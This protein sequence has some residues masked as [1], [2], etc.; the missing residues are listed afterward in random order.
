MRMKKKI[1]I[2]IKT[3]YFRL[4]LIENKMASKKNYYEIPNPIWLLLVSM[5]IFVS[6]YSILIF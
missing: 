1:K 6:V 2:N 3:L 5:I 4:D